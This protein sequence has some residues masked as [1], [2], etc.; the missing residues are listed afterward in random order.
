MKKRGQGK[1]LLLFSNHK[2][3][4]SCF[5]RLKKGPKGYLC[6][7]RLPQNAKLPPAFFKIL[8]S[9]TKIKVFYRKKNKKHRE[10]KKT[11]NFYL[12]NTAANALKVSRNTRKKTSTPH[13]YCTKFLGWPNFL[14]AIFIFFLNLL[15]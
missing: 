5:Y 9:S 15:P 7:P 11:H 13:F 4:I 1:A 10:L 12:Q 6:R 2:S 3:S 8:S 14:H